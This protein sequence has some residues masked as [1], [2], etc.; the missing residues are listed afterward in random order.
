MEG[1]L[2]RPI[3]K[4]DHHYVILVH[5]TFNKP[6]EKNPHWCKLDNLD[7]N[8]FAKRLNEC[9][10]KTPIGSVVNLSPD[11]NID[12]F[13]WEGLNTHED[14]VKAG[15]QLCERII[16][17]TEK[18]PNARIHLVGHS[19]GGNVILSAIQAYYNFLGQTPNHI[20]SLDW[21]A[22][23]WGD[24]TRSFLNNQATDLYPAAK[25][26]VSAIASANK[27][28]LA[29]LLESLS[30]Y[31]WEQ[32][33][34]AGEMEQAVNE[35][36]KYYL[37]SPTFNR[38]GRIIF[39]GTPF[40]YKRWRRGNPLYWLK[41][42]LLNVLGLFLYWG[43]TAWVISFFIYM[44]PSL[45]FGHGFPWNPFKWSLIIQILAG[46]YLLINIVKGYRETRRNGNVY[47][48]HSDFERF[49]L[50][51]P[52][53]LESIG[54]KIV[55]GRLSTLTVA[56]PYFDEAYLALSGDSLLFGK[57]RSKLREFLVPKRTAKKND[58]LASGIRLTRM[59]A[60]RTL[61][62]GAIEFVG[63]KIMQFIYLVFIEPLWKLTYFFLLENPLLKNVFGAITSA[64]TGLPNTEFDQAVIEVHQKADIPEVLNETILDGGNIFEQYLKNEINVPVTQPNNQ[65]GNELETYL[66]LRND[67]ELAK[68]LLNDEFWNE[69]ETQLAA[70]SKFF[71]RTDIKEFTYELG[72]KWLSIKERTSSIL[73]SV[74]LNH[75]RY[76][77]DQKIIEAIAAFIA[78]GNVESLLCEKNDI[79][80][81]RKKEKKR[82][83]TKTRYFK[84]ETQKTTLPHSVLQKRTQNEVEPARVHDEASS[85]TASLQKCLSELLINFK[86]LT[87][88]TAITTT[89]ITNELY[90]YFVQD[91]GRFFPVHWYGNIF[92]NGYYELPV[93]GIGPYHAEAFCDWL[94]SVFQAR[95]LFRTPTTEEA[96]EIKAVDPTMG[97]WSTYKNSDRRMIGRRSIRRMYAPLRKYSGGSRV[98]FSKKGFDGISLSGITV[99]NINQPPVDP[100]LTELISRAIF[101]RRPP[102]NLWQLPKGLAVLGELIQN[103]Q[104]GQINITNSI[105]KAKV[106]LGKFT[107]ELARSSFEP[108]SIS[109]AKWTQFIQEGQKDKA[110]GL[111]ETLCESQEVEIAHSAHL[112]IDFVQ[113]S[114]SPDE[115]QAYYYLQRATARLLEYCYAAF[116]FLESVRKKNLGTRRY[117]YEKYI[118]RFFKVS[119]DSF[120]YDRLWSY[121]WWYRLAMG[122]HEKKVRAVEGIRI[123]FTGT[124]E[125]F[126][127]ISNFRLTDTKT[128]S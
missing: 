108:S 18:D 83:A 114:D 26:M 22:W 127:K 9:L 44:L 63:R 105:E 80:P 99:L 107:D 92:D 11:G 79:K 48:N 59:V 31:I 111:L 96:T 56:A 102:E 76:Y 49:E 20:A 10:S 32:E 61:F 82:K 30:Y 46:L 122:R 93:T 126:N 74:T 100:L 128:L 5:G 86:W 19:H 70:I 36:H 35:Y 81:P 51:T 115:D 25:R 43:L 124:K 6:E 23:R 84:F 2:P 42:H 28:I 85:T 3:R 13:V 1:V 120:E 106:C 14:R 121:Y 37:A 67:E 55:D 38:I 119:D 64:S 71:E 62:T 118:G 12:T 52:V 78:D 87:N 58:A 53:E 125:Y 47:C 116:S 33:D 41:H 109:F 50:D 34:N 4:N 110:A 8:N 75:S 98:P 72:K 113:A 101:N 117:F 73:E 39:L 60:L 88:K 17:T 40:M 104:N 29:T 54:S 27:N 112:I 94:T 103:M 97:C 90:L 77:A 45:I 21:W 65:S 89:F 69:F 24:M 68:R 91:R 16:K 57:L 123:V 7:P 15:K 66:F 95:I